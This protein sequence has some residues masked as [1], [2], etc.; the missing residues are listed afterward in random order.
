[1]QIT[2]LSISFPLCYYHLIKHLWLAKFPTAENSFEIIFAPNIYTSKQH[3]LINKK[4][5]I[6][7][8]LEQIFIYLSNNCPIEFWVIEG[9]QY[10]L[11]FLRVVMDPERKGHLDY[12]LALVDCGLLVNHS[13]AWCWSKLWHFRCPTFSSLPETTGCN[14]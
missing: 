8:I 7:R 12:P 4:L 3:L 14:A 1:M 11:K 5:S 13:R 9:V 6:K 2:L 10:E